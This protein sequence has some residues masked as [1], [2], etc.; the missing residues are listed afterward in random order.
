MI[1]EIYAMCGWDVTPRELKTITE[2]LFVYGVNVICQHLVPYSEHGQRK[3]DYPAHYSEYNPWVK[4]DFKSFN[5]YFARLGYL[6]GESEEIVSVGLF[7][8]VSSMYFDYKQGVPKTYDADRSYLEIAL[9]LGKANVPFHILDEKIMEGHGRVEGKELVVGNCRYKFVIL[10]KTL[11]LSDFSAKILEEFYAA[12]GKIL[13]VEGVPEYLKWEKHD[14][15]MKSN[16]SFEE[17]ALAQPYRIGDANT[18]I[19]STLRR[20]KEGKEFIFATNVSLEKSYT[21]EFSGK[22]KGFIKLDLETL[23]TEKVGT[24]L[25]FNAGDSYV[26]FLSEERAEEKEEKRKLVLSGEFGIE[27]SSENYMLLDKPR[28]SEN[29]FDYGERTRY[30]GIFEELLNKRYNG[31]LYLKYEFEVKALPAVMKFGYEDMNVEALEINGAAADNAVFDETEERYYSDITDKVKIGTNEAVL[32]INFYESERTYYALF[33]EGVTETLK[34]CIAYETTVEACLLKGEFGVYS[35]GGFTKGTQKNVLIAKDDFFVGEPSKKV[36]NTVKEG[37]PFFAGNMTFVKEFEWDGGDCILDLS[38]RY[39]L[40]YLEINGKAVPKSY[41]G[42][43]ADISEF[44]KKGKNRAKITLYASN[45]NL[46]GPHCLADS[47][48]CILVGPFSWELQGSWKNGKSDRERE[49]Y[50]FIKFGLF[51]D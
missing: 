31:K 47:E 32:K 48:E 50:S 16:I 42:K 4:K 18:E 11:T 9:K 35:S 37:Y 38:G 15:A 39:S 49:S 36:T 41:F 21:A 13:F 5:D 10:P 30:M 45:R 14:Y 24:R 34:N 29:G 33:G 2:W 43:S 3:R 26:L 12:G 28:Y 40:C 1:G 7:S 17:I 6:L 20:T 51:G 44:V 8:P 27:N 46:L 19:A 22:F 23:K 25:N